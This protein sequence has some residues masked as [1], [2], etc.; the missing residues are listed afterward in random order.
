MRLTLSVWAPGGTGLCVG[1]VKQLN[2]SFGEGENFTTA[3]QLSNALNT[4]M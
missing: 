3:K 1:I 2:I 4:V